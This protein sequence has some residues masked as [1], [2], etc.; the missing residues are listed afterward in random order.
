MEYVIRILDI[1]A[2]PASVMVLLWVGRKP[3]EKLLSFIESVK[4]K[5]VEVKF[6][7]QLA[8]VEEDVGDTILD[9]SNE[10]ENKSELY[11][12]IEVSPSSAIIEAWKGLEIAARNKV[13]ELMSPGEQYANALHRP[14]DYLE[15][16]GALIPSTA[17]AIR[18]MRGLRNQSAHAE[19][20]VISKENAVQYS[21][22][23]RAIKKQ[24]EGI[25]DLP[26]IKLTALTLLIM[27]LNHL[28]DSGKFNDISI[29]EVYE[30][31][32][33]KSILPFLTQ[34]TKGV[35]DFSLYSDDGP[36]SNFTK[37]YHEQ[38]ACLYGGYGG[39]HRRKWGVENLGLCLLLAWT[40]ELI[41][42]GA[43]WHPNEM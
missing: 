27:E 20:K 8:Q 1:L 36:Y 37:F 18:E 24:I 33:N 12:L 5:D 10:V 13:K 15:Y 16:S 26:K 41:Q 28:V 19:G 6:G 7:K 38:M 31:I 39:D 40:N 4:Y 22:L 25:T 3:I 34:R 14:L 43:G 2:W 21:G 30:H 11:A 29:D 9:E 17:R 23:A 32:E 42:Q 35:S